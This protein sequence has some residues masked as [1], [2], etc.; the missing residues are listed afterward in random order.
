MP[1]KDAELQDLG[2]NDCFWMFRTPGPKPWL[3]FLRVQE[4]YDERYLEYCSIFSR[5]EYLYAS[6]SNNRLRDLQLRL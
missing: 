3:D 5:F 1:S 2:T 6:N 4:S